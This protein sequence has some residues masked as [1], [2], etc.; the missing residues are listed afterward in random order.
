[1]KHHSD[2]NPQ[3]NIIHEWGQSDC[4]END[5]RG[6]GLKQERVTVSHVD[7]NKV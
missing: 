4:M 7:N 5:T 6:G 1:M 2:T 3:F